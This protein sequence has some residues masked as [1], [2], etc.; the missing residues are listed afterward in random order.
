MSGR[1]ELPRPVGA[2]FA[3]L[4]PTAMG[5]EARADL[6]AEYAR[7]RARHYRL[8][9]LFW[10]FAQ[11]LRP[12]TWELAWK[13]RRVHRRRDGSRST[14]G[15]APSS[16]FGG[17]WLDVKLA[18]RMLRRY[19]VLTLIGVL[20]ISV[21]VGAAAGFHAVT[22]N[23]LDPTLPIPE[24]DRLVGIQSWDRTT[25]RPA[26]SIL[27]DYGVWRDEL[28][29][30]E[31]VGAFSPFQPNLILEDGR[32]IS[33]P[34]SRIT[35]SAFANARVRPL[36]GRAIVESDEQPGATDVAVIGFD[37]WHDELGG[38]P[39][40]LGRVVR[41]GAAPHTIVGVMP[42]GF[43]FPYADDLWV[44]LREDPRA[45]EPAEGPFVDVVMARLREGIEIEE[46]QAELNVLGAR[47]AAEHPDT[48]A[49]MSPRVEGYAQSLWC[50]STLQFS[51]GRAVFVML[52]IVV[53]A[54]VGAL[55]Y[56]R[57]AARMPEMS[58]RR[59]LGA[60]R[61]RILVQLFVE[62]MVLST[63]GAVIGV[64][65]VRWGMRALADIAAGALPGGTVRLP[66]YWQWDLAPET[67]FYIGA[68]T[69]VTAVVIGLL[70]AVKLT[71]QP[72]GKWLR[73]AGRAGASPSFGRMAKT[74][75]ALQVGLSVGLLAVAV[76]QLPTLVRIG[77]ASV[78]GIVPDQYITARLEPADVS[79]EELGAAVQR[80]DQMARELRPRLMLEPGVRSVTL[81][82]ALP[83]MTHPE[84]L[85]E[86][87]G[88]T[89]LEPLP[90]RVA[91]V[92][93]EYFES[94]GVP[95]ADGRPFDSGDFASDGSAQPVVIANR[96]FARRAFGDMSAL[97]RRVRFVIPG[98]EPGPWL[99][100][101]GISED[102]GMNFSDPGSPQG[103][104]VPLTGDTFPV[105]LAVRLGADAASFEARLRA[106]AA[107][108][109]P[110]IRLV[111]VRT[112]DAFL[113]SVR[114]RQRWSYLGIL[115]ATLST[116]ALSLS[117]VYAV[118]SFFVVQRTA[119]I[120]VRVALGATS[121][122]IALGVVSRALLPAMVGT[123]LGGILSVVLASALDLRL[124]VALAVSLAMLGAVLL[125]CIG[126]LRRATGMHPTRAIQAGI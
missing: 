71:R 12:S 7:L 14:S 84:Q 37:V 106:H 101:V 41:I 27:Y 96:A 116:I 10:C 2:I 94:L 65:L 17:S 73:P 30:V 4:F 86:I 15:S 34:G 125:A 66:F 87:E 39:N 93:P 81:A 97:G 76:G 77:E 47:M 46:A 89:R 22:Q 113:E 50:C 100:I 53:C 119:E 57:N 63:L 88:G 16:L 118:T 18:W 44:P 59:A 114:T 83:G 124:G 91:R 72:T 3:W 103:L 13:L 25:N 117:G 48:H 49:S 26:T 105:S 5:D 1:R 102:L 33:V 92:E 62:A 64:A 68:S 112:L 99:E 121:A 55:V 35:A 120:G 60:S 56:A 98:A 109:D 23:F 6:E 122:R 75:I 115:V 31:D 8:F 108:V 107:A 45:V 36:L 54:N 61:G 51:V 21:A 38:D 19:P 40:V 85:I 52:L 126:P 95:I 74:A 28:G 29:T 104:Y 42:K 70:P 32:S 79:A 80:I 82:N 111:G 20:S 67:L 110:T 90:A 58:V 43:R 69:V 9:G 78:R 11:L 24:G 123:A